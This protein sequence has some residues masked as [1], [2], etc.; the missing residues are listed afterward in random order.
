MAHT[1]IFVAVV[2]TAENL[3]KH[4]SCMNMVRKIKGKRLQ[5][6]TC[7]VS[8][9]RFCRLGFSIDKVM[10]GKCIASGICSLFSELMLAVSI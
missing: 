3:R 7:A 8:C 6:D 2:F 4:L 9:H 5:F 1:E 10:N